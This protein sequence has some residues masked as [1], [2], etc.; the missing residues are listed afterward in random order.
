MTAPPTLADVLVHRRGDVATAVAALL[1]SR[2]WFAGKAR[3]VREVDVAD[4]A[5]VDADVA[6]L[7]VTVRYAAGTDERYQ[8]PVTSR[9]PADVAEAEVVAR[10]GDAVLVDATAVQEG[11]LAIAGLAASGERIT[12]IAG[13]TVT[14]SWE[15]GAELARPVRRMGVEQSNT[16]V[17]FGDRVVLKVLRRLEE[18]ENP[19]V[20][21]TRA[22]TRAGCDHVPAFRGAVSL[23]AHG[24]RVTT[25]AVL[26]D[27]LA[28][29][30]E[31]WDLATQ[32]AAALAA[33]GP[34]GGGG[35][36]SGL[37]GRARDLGAAVEAVH[38]ALQQALGAQ[39]AAPSAAAAGVDAMRAQLDRVLAVA[40]ARAPGPT[41]PVLAARERIAAALGAAAHVTD[42]GPLLRIHGDLHLGQVLLDAGGRWQVLDFE[43][44]P[45][46]PLAERRAPASP[47]RDVAGML[48]SFDYAVGHAVLTGAGARPDAAHR[49]DAW[50]DGLRTAFLDGYLDAARAAGVLPGDEASTAA[51]LA[52]FELDKAVYELGYELA[53]RPDWVPIPV[54]GILR[55]LDRAPR[56]APAATAR[57]T[58]PATEGPAV[59]TAGSRPAK[60]AS[61]PTAPTPDPPASTPTATSGEDPAVAT[62]TDPA[63]APTLRGWRA[64]AGEVRALIDGRHTDPHRLLG[65][66]EVE[67]GTGVVRVYR[68][69]A[70]SVE[71][72]DTAGGVLAEAERTHDGGLF[73]A[74]LDRAVAGTAYRVR[75]R[76]GS[77]S[78]YTLVD[79][80]AFWPT[81][82]EVDLHLLGEGRHEEL[83]RRLGA[84]PGVADGISGTSFAV[85]APNARSVRV[86]AGFNSWDGRLH[87]MRLLG[88]SGIWELFVP[89]AGPGTHYKYEIVT[90]DGALVTRADPYAFATEVPPG[91][92]SRVFAS[93]FQWDDDEWMRTRHSRQA[94]DA[95]ISVYEVHLASWRHRGRRSLTYRELA[96]DLVGHVR[97][98]GFTHV[99]LLPPA[100]HPFGPS[101][102]YQV[103]GYFAP[104][105]RFGDP[106]DFRYLV[107]RLH[108]AGIGVLVDWVP[109][110]FPKDSW[111]LARFDGTALYEHADP[112][113]GEHPDWGTLVFNYGRNEVRNFLIANAL[114]WLEEL[115]VDG[116]RVDAVASM[117]YLDYSRE[118]GQWVPN[119]FGGNENLEAVDFLKELNAVVYGRNASAVT[120][121][122]ESTAWPGVSRPVHL[123]GLGFGFKWN[124]GWMH[125]TLDYMAR[126]PIHRRYH[127]HQMT[128]ALMYAFS[129]NFVLPLS[130]DEVV[131]GKRSLIDKMPGDRWQKFA[132]LRA[133]YGYMWAHPGKQLLFMGGEFGQ[134]REWSEQRELDWWLL[135]EPDHQGLQSLVAELNHRYRALP[136][137][138]QRDVDPNGFQWIDA[139][140]ADDNV[141]GFVRFGEQSVAPVVC[142]TNFSPVPRT[143]RTGL[144]GEGSYREILN[145][146]AEG[147]GGANIGNLGEV[148]GEP[149]PWHG[150]PASAV[151]TVPPLG[152]IW[153][154]KEF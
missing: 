147:Y 131:H 119:R 86:V 49:L 85:W 3:T 46:R 30:R 110:H 130:H 107:D 143:L 25:L 151:V 111:A 26:S 109:A 61:G 139:N 50:R 90:A 146:D 66:H 70:A 150:Q 2:R 106:D 153:L 114:F 21:L 88:G 101:W 45:A 149:T 63:S 80:Y 122:E 11:A 92:A 20:E 9:V 72:L 60:A 144:P 75:V 120:V 29:A 18:D 36:P 103:T 12:T 133:L 52:A 64:P 83:W 145:T 16:S 105:A 59:S 40:A 54:G 116:L 53:N 6:I 118:E 69:D 138:W 38:A 71:V 14:G 117:L 94:V 84:H 127:H 51:L 28:G 104:T 121:A 58:T 96:D 87:P 115:H 152:T 73:E 31:G 56:R 141:F 125:D 132:N 74:H 8:L 22:L 135:D 128:F 100:E 81:L 97:Y 78:E 34:R 23:Q 76:Y 55:V 134:W 44:E 98:L 113:Q 129:E 48:R 77:G 62:S 79:A 148:H 154:E 7:L 65:A 17:V 10:L 5:V 41:A 33:G 47:L 140:N 19:E 123:G 126:E 42:P 93:T 99:E 39:H 137:L 67:D 35:E 124:M 24:G 13:R 102:G 4:V 37:S 91:T 43:G 136:A 27:F 57:P 32:E 112:R 82:G 89:D 68:P 1:P 108:A 95:P 142:L 15:G